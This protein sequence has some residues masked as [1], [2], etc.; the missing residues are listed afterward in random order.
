MPGPRI[1]RD[2][3][4]NLW[5]DYLTKFEQQVMIPLYE[6]ESL[7]IKSEPVP[8]FPGKLQ[9]GEFGK[10]VGIDFKY[11]RVLCFDYYGLFKLSSTIIECKKDLVLAQKK[12]VIFS[13]VIHF[14]SVKIE[15]IEEYSKD[16]LLDFVAFK[17]YI[18]Y[19]RW[20]KPV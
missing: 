6:A 18:V 3:M 13:P 20:T 10:M 2:K 15:H 19:L 9:G 11:D 4:D 7:S 1:G 17:R 8:L 5:T 12:T 14:S 16:L